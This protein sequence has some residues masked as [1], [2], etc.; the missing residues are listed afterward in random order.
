MAKLG[1][2]PAMRPADFGSR[3]CFAALGSDT[4]MDTVCTDGTGLFYSEVTARRHGLP[5]MSIMCS[6]LLCLLRSPSG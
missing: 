3:R 6:T 2:V 5:I 4:L 1:C